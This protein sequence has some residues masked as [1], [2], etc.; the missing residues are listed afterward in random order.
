M[1]IYLIKTRNANL[2]ADFLFCS[3]ISVIEFVFGNSHLGRV[4]Y[5]YRYNTRTHPFLLENT[6]SDPRLVIWSS[7]MIVP[8]QIKTFGGLFYFIF[9]LVWFYLDIPIYR[10]VLYCSYEG[11]VYVFKKEIRSWDG[12]WQE[13]WRSKSDISSPQAGSWII[14]QNGWALPAATPS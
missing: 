10:R 2:S 14:K 5:L 9:F 4:F 13:R 3:K 6:V 11:C 8:L 7:Y 1:K 12:W